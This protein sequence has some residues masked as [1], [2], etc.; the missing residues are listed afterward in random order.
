LEVKRGDLVT[1]VLSG[2]SGNPR[3]ALV[4]QSDLFEAHPSITILPV[5]SE[6]REAPL[7]RVRVEPADVNGLSRTSEVMVDRLQT[8]ARERIGEAIGRLDDVAMLAVNRA[9]AVFLGFA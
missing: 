1:I 9:L 3:P 5:T 6:L 7:F 4:I 8:V 2:D